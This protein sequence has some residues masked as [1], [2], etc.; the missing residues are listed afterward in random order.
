[1]SNLE[2]RNRLITRN[3]EA[4]WFEILWSWRQMKS[5]F[6]ENG[7]QESH[8]EK[9]FE[10]CCLWG[11]RGTCLWRP[12]RQKAYIPTSLCTHLGGVWWKDIPSPPSRA[13]S[14]AVG[15]NYTTVA[16][17]QRK[18]WP[19]ISPLYTQTAKGHK[20]TKPG[21]PG[22]ADFSKWVMELPCPVC[23]MP[24]FIHLSAKK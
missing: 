5:Q 23:P 16:A 1:M 2:G 17:L 12:F 9:L 7:K 19:L 14:S 20:G 11:D 15:N 6:L 10:R 3:K 4:W 18:F 8:G 24:H 22:Q 21:S 13:H